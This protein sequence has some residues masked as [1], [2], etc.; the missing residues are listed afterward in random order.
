MCQG[1]NCLY[2][3]TWVRIPGLLLTSYKVLV[4]IVDFPEPQFSRCQ[5]SAALLSCYFDFLK[6][7]PSIPKVIH[8]CRS[9]FASRPQERACLGILPI[10]PA[11][12]A[13]P[14]SLSLGRPQ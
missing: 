8:L 14:A 4:K 6:Q 3:Q 12:P 5:I 1:N 10:P 9:G 13:R 11:E 2:C 7:N